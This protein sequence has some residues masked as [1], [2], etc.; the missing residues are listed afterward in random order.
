MH[1]NSIPVWFCFFD[2]TL[3]IEPDQK[4]QRV[5]VFK[6]VTAGVP[7][8]TI[9]STT[10]R[11]PYALDTNTATSLK[12]GKEVPTI[13]SG[14]LKQKLFCYGGGGR[15]SYY[16]S[17]LKLRQNLKKENPIMDQNHDTKLLTNSLPNL[18][19]QPPKWDP[20]LGSKKKF[21]KIVAEQAGVKMINA[22]R[23]S[24]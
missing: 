14:G 6:R 8:L 16:V 17:T 23:R 11:K 3:K 7:V 20:M 5:E 12:I 10:R 13:G 24:F 15:V 9:T 19:P 1:S 18:W 22:T 2:L 4:K 21:P